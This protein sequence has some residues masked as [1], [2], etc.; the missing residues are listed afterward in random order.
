MAESR[1]TYTSY[2]LTTPQ[3]LWDALV[4]PEKTRLHWFDSRLESD[5]TAGRA[6]SSSRPR[7]A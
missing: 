7:A 1:F 2:I 5:W 4:N 6:G 3:A